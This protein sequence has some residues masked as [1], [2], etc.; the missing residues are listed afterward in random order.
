M[1]TRWRTPTGSRSRNTPKGRCSTW[2][3]TSLARVQ[4]HHDTFFN[5]NSLYESGAVWKVLEALEERGYTYKAV[6]REDAT[7]EEREE[8]GGQRRSRSGFAARHSATAKTA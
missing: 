7:P 6:A 2:I 3:K 8:A 4:I 5:E 1:A